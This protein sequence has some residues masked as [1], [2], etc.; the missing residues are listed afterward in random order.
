MF[1]KLHIIKSSF[2]KNMLKVKKTMFKRNICWNAQDIM[3]FGYANINATY[4]YLRHFAL[5]GDWL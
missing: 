4:I 3:P 2:R 5:H 1:T